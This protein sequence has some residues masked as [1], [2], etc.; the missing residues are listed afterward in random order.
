MC[1]F[2]SCFFFVIKI[3]DAT[4]IQ[5]HTEVCIG[6]NFM[7]E[8]SNDEIAR[9]KGICILNFDRYRTVTFPRDRSN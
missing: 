9:L 5:K 6:F 8:S 1:I 3:W 2:T 4:N 7:A